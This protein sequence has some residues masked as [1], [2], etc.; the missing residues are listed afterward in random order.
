MA[1]F[2]PLDISGQW[3]RLNDSIVDLVD[4]VPADR[5][6]W[7]PREDLFNFRGIF[8]HIAIARH[9]WMGGVV[10]DGEEVDIRD[11]LSNLGTPDAVKQHLRDSWTRIAKFLSDRSA[12]DASYQDQEGDVTGH[13][14]AFHLLEHDVHHRADVFHYLALLEI[15]HPD[16]GTP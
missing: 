13:W 11:I 7:S 14:I 5:V 3:S 8:A 2:V 15:E 4:Y 9:N 12:L 1:G 10:H 16:V 6:D